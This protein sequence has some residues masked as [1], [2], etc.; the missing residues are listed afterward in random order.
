MAI[1]SLDD[2]MPSKVL[3]YDLAF[4]DDFLFAI[5]YRFKRNITI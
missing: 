4:V 2:Q 3:P 5:P 1:Q